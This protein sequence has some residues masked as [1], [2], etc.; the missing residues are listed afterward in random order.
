MIAPGIIYLD[1][2]AVA[3]VLFREP[4]G[5][6]MGAVLRECE[7]EGAEVASSQILRVELHRAALR[8][9]LQAGKD[10]YNRDS[11]ERAL[12]SITLYEINHRVLDTAISLRPYLG[13]LDSIHVATAMMLGPAV[14]RFASLDLAQC[15]V[16]SVNGLETIPTPGW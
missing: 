7:L 4:A 10:G 11:V 5:E 1:T 6:A 13:S 12:A 14:V 3:S 15:E 9:A 2:S 16:A 8:N